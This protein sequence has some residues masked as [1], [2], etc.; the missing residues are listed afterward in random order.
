MVAQ[1]LYDA[2]GVDLGWEIRRGSAMKNW[3]I[4]IIIYN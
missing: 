3:I 4:I 2:I 1:H